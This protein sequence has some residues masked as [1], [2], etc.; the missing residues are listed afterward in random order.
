MVFYNM[1]IALLSEANR[2]AIVILYTVILK[3][4]ADSQTSAKLVAFDTFS[5]LETAICIVTFL[6]ALEYAP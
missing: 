4:N 2:R 6:S 5:A 3:F 1:T